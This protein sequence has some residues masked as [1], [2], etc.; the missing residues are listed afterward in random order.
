STPVPSN[1][2]GGKSALIDPNESKPED[3]MDDPSKLQQQQQQQ[4][5]HPLLQNRSRP[6]TPNFYPNMSPANSPYYP[7]QRPMTPTPDYNMAS[8]AR[9]IRPVNVGYGNLPVQRIRTPLPSQLS[10]PTNDPTTG[11]NNNPMGLQSTPPPP[12]SVNPR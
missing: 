9:G 8:A 2:A 1:G 10:S 12:P 4:M 6:Q 7:P 3:M 5:F 11:M